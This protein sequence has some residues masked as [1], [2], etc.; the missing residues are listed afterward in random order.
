MRVVGTEKR[1]RVS[2]GCRL[3]RAQTDEQ[4]PTD[5]DDDTTGKPCREEG[6]G[7]RGAKEGSRRHRTPARCPACMGVGEKAVAGERS[8]ELGVEEE[9]AVFGDELGLVTGLRS[10]GQMSGA[11]ACAGVLEW[12]M[13][14]A[15]A[16]IAAHSTEYNA[17][18]V[19]VGG[20]GPEIC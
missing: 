19:E 18:V 10:D 4:P 5:E 8:T 11:F 15:A 9:S 16:R 2:C 13:L 1:L 6:K 7:R 12:S 17:V 14:E 20:W 3:K